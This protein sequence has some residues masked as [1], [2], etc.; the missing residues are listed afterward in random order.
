MCFDYVKEWTMLKD[1][2]ETKKMPRI[3]MLV[4]P[5]HVNLLHNKTTHDDIIYEVN[6][7]SKYCTFM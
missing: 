5:E 1:C 7:A 4:G 6:I 3:V 2:R